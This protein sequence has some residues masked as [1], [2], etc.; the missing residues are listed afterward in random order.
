MKEITPTNSDKPI[1]VDDEDWTELNS[2][3]WYLLPKG[4]PVR[5][6]KVG[7]TKKYTLEYMAHVIV[8]KH[9]L[10][11]DLPEWRVTYHDDNHAN[12]CKENLRVLDI[13]TMNHIKN[14]PKRKDDTP[15]RGVRT[16]YVMIKDGKKHKGYRKHRRT[17]TIRYR[18]EMTVKRNYIYL[19]Y[20]KTPEEAARQYDRHAWVV[21]G[22][23]ANLNFP[24]EYAKKRESLER[25][26]KKEQERKAKDRIRGRNKRELK[27]ELLRSINKI[28]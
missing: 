24:E 28:S 11:K 7:K 20:F 25:R 15:Y 22:L 17:K 9:K 14:V 4:Y 18:A 19:G 8:E 13:N 2:V 3:S 12:L 23:D 10:Y 6:V 21:Y 27:K 5:N 26:L 16:V 1:L